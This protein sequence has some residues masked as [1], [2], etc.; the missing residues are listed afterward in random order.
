LTTAPVLAYPNF[1]TNFL[2]QTDASGIALGAVL[3]QI[4]E[5]KRVHPVAYASRQLSKP[6]KRYSA[7]E[8]EALAVVWAMKHF[9]Y[10]LFGVHT[11][12]FFDHKPLVWLL[13]SKLPEG[14]LAKWTLTLQE[15]KF[16]VNYKSGKEN[17]NADALSRL[18][19]RDLASP[20]SAVLTKM[21]P[22]MSWEQLR[23]EQR[24]DKSLI[25]FFRILVGE[26]RQKH[27]IKCTYT[28]KMVY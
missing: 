3:G 25:R 11:T 23:D 2:L 9:R 6:E 4:G 7:T 21:E 13:K 24:K 10:C 17:S 28:I 1:K 27:P 8:R 20:V 14:R 19:P 22:T 15:Y 16:D 18:T 12:V 26:N 5:D